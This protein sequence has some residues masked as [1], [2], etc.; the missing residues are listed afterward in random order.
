MMLGMHLEIQNKVYEEILNIVGEN[1]HSITFEDLP[2]MKYLERVIKET[3]RLF[4]VG[5]IIGRSAT[6]DVQL[7]KHSKPKSYFL[8]V[9]Y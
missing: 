8:K 5:A 2:K 3:M 9:T 4:P 7:S 6:E 1:D